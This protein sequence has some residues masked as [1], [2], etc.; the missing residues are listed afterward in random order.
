MAKYVIAKD[1][2]RDIWKA[3]RIYFGLW[4]DMTYKK[5]CYSCLSADDCIEHLIRVHNEGKKIEVKR[6]RI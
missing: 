3:Y 2:N 6:F 1:M 5:G 4:G